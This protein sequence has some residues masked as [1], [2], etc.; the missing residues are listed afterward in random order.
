MSIYEQGLE[1][2]IFD[3]IVHARCVTPLSHL[4]VHSVAQR[5][6]N[7]NEPSNKTLQFID[8]PILLSF[9]VTASAAL[10][11]AWTDLD[12]IHYPPIA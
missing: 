6:V 2:H 11:Y 8:A 4:S 3:L 10:K 12:P 5:Q 1:W 9:H 7:H